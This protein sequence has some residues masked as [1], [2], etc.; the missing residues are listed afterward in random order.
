MARGYPETY[1]FTY[2]KGKEMETV[3]LHRPRRCNSHKSRH[4]MKRTLKTI[5]KRTAEFALRELGIVW[6]PKRVVNV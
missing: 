3:R 2:A 6:T 1:R 4:I 5:A